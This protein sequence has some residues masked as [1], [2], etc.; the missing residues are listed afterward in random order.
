MGSQNQR[1]QHAELPTAHG[2]VAQPSECAVHHCSHLPQLMVGYEVVGNLHVQL[3]PFTVC[4]LHSNWVTSCFSLSISL[5]IM[6]P[7][8]LLFSTICAS[9]KSWSFC[10]KG[11]LIL[12]RIMPSKGRKCGRVWLSTI[13]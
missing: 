9:T 10:L 12:Q 2:D 11:S 4:D 6:G 8:F 7:A 3:D 1:A 5:P 13:H